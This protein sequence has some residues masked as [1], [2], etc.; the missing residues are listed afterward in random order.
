MTLKALVVSYAFPPVGGAGVQRMLKLVKYLPEHGVRPCVLTVARASVPV[1]DPSLLREV[2]PEVPILRAPTLEPGYAAKNLAWRAHAEA[3]RR[4]R[5]VP[6]QALS[7]LGRELLLPDPQVLWLPGAARALVRRLRAERDQV[8]LVSGPPFS[9]FMLGPLAAVA[10][11]TPFVLDYRDEWTTTS[12]IYE[13]SGSTRLATAL[14]RFVVARASAITTATEEF[15]EH[16]LERFAFL[17]PARVFA[18]PNGYDP[19]DFP[20]ELPAPASDRCVITYSGTVFRLTSARGFLAGLRLFAE[21]EPKLAAWL[22]VRFIGRIVETEADAFD[23]SAWLGV[24]RLGYL[25]H[26]EALASLASSHLALCLLA[27]L[28]G[29]ERIYPAKIFEIMRLGRPALVL[30][31]EGALSR[32]VRRHRLGE[33]VAPDDPPAIAAAL[34]RSARAFVAGRLPL[35]ASAVDIERFDRRRLAGEFARVLASAAE[36]V[37]ASVRS[38]GV[39]QASRIAFAHR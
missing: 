12:S 1:L 15:R 29:S 27:D 17:D 6:L 31:P 19:A 3:P 2:P 11:R 20:A 23:D 38:A 4:R 7:K 16:L 35:S 18:L 36:S 21:R 22:D 33:I 34:E 13:M 8:V 37:R 30:T 14:E 5:A 10:C 26:A 25:P 32:L 9:Q 24:R 28:P 39:A